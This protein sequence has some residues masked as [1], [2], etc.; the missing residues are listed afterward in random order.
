VFL[1]PILQEPSHAWLL[2]N[3]RHGNI[4][5]RTIETAFDRHTRNRGL[6]G[7]SSLD[8]DTALILAPCNSIHTFFMK[9]PI[10]VA[11]IDKRG[12]IRRARAA[13]GPWRIQ[14]SLTSFAVI[15]LEAGALER[16]GTRAGDQLVLSRD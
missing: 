1:E 15:E 4:V 13:V 6:L 3:T 8:R 11:F 2:R 5:A 12:T 10:D 7:R 16:S 9:F 14:L